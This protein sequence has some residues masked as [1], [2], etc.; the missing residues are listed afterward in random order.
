M[1]KVRSIFLTLAALAGSLYASPFSDHGQLSIKDGIV[2]DKNSN[3]AQLRGMSLF[4]DKWA[5]SWYNSGAV[6]TL[7]SDWKADVIRA[8]ISAYDETV[9]KNMID[10]SI[11]AGIYVVVDNHSHSAHL[12]TSQAASYF[13][14]IAQYVAGKGASS[15]S[16]IYEIYNEPVCSDGGDPT[17]NCPGGYT[18]W[19]TIK[20]Y[21]ET[22]IAAI[23][24]YDTKNIII[25]GT[26]KFSQGVGDAMA[27]PISGNNIA[28]ALHFYASE[29]SHINL[30]GVVRGAYC[31]QFP[32]VITEWGT[33]WANGNTGPNG[34]GY[35]WSNVYSWMGLI[36]SAK[37]SWMNWSLYDKS[38]LASALQGG[39]ST[40]GPWNN[41]TQSGSFVKGAMVNLANKSPVPN[42]S[43][44]SIDCSYLSS[45]SSSRTGG[46]WAGGVIEAENYVSV[47][48]TSEQS[49]AS[50]SGTLYMGAIQ[51]GAELNYWV[52]VE[53][54]GWYDMHLGASATAEGA[55]YSY[56]VNGSTVLGSIASTGS[57]TTFGTNTT[58]VK[59]AQ[60][61]YDIK[62]TV[63]NITPNLGL[64]YLLFLKADSLDSIAYDQEVVRIRD[65]G[66][67]NR[68]SYKWSGSKL[69]IH[70]PV[71][72]DVNSIS[73]YDLTGK[74]IRFWGRNEITDKVV[75]DAKDFKSSALLFAVIQTSSGIQTIKIP[76]VHQ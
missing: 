59:L 25:V 55:T 5:G 44:S 56:T 23:R 4:W 60:G 21:A 37:V 1:K 35:N 22:V 26:P 50:A 42:V 64:D 46:F 67:T 76:M 20:Q 71:L 28:Y 12:Q 62:L 16:V 8:A 41:L 51:Q 36:E 17:S 10:W 57:A 73:I 30:Q 33:S 48:G 11:N 70:S 47:T 63:T 75:F 72:T 24:K 15:G 39:A 58:H 6:N 61:K 29:T 38:E 31:K 40:S 14:H 74:K 9:T 45:S 19:T 49:A 13:G 69:E 52:D 7:A 2:V 3:P 32:I 43:S 65:N 53:K 54:A 27:N 18:N 68:L 66:S 34:Q